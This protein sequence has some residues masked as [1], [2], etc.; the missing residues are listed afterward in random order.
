MKNYEIKYEILKNF[1]CPLKEHQEE[2][3]MIDFETLPKKEMQTT[4]ETKEKV[5]E[6]IY[7][8]L[9]KYFEKFNFTIT[10]LWAQRYINGRHSAHIHPQCA[11][12][13]IWYVKADENCSKILFYNPGWPY[14]DTHKFEIQPVTGTLLLFSAGIP[15]EVLENKNQI[16]N[17]IAGNLKWLK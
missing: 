16:R 15:H 5:N 2:F 13:F 8:F 11:A 10:N 4:Y 7:F 6:K 1:L 3:D 14:I 9:D 12:S 17:V